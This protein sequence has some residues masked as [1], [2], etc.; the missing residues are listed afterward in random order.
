MPLSQKQL[1]KKMKHGDIRRVALEVAALD[2]SLL[3]QDGCSGEKRGSHGNAE[4]QYAV[5]E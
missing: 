2:Y 1:T 3:D 5:S 4:G